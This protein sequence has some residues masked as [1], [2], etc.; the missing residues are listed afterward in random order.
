MEFNVIIMSDWHICDNSYRNVNL[1][2]LTMA[3]INASSTDKMNL[4]LFSGDI[5]QSGKSE[6]YDLALA[7]F[8]ELSE[9][10]NHF[11]IKINYM[12]SPGNHDVLFESEDK[13]EMISYFVDGFISNPSNKHIQSQ[14]LEPQSNY[15]KFIKNVLFDNNQNEGDEF[16]SARKY[17]FDNHSSLSIFSLN[18][19]FMSKKHEIYG[20]HKFPFQYYEDFVNDYKSSFNILF[21]HHPLNWFDFDTRSKQHDYIS[22]KQNLI[23]VGHEHYNEDTL[24][25]KSNNCWIK[26]EKL[27][28][29]DGN[30]AFISVN[31]SHGTIEKRVYVYD[32]NDEKYISS[33]IPSS[34]TSMKSTDSDLQLNNEFEKYLKDIGMLILHPR[35]QI[36]LEDI[37]IE[38]NLLYTKHKNET[39]IEYDN[40]VEEIDYESFKYCIIGEERS[41]KTTILKKLFIEFYKKNLIP[42][43]IK[44]EDLELV[45]KSVE[46]NIKLILE[47]NYETKLDYNKSKDRFVI[48]IDNI[49]SLKL[50]N[51]KKY[52]DFINALFSSFNKIIITNNTSTLIL[53]E[54]LAEHEFN[55]YT[56]SLLKKSQR[57]TLINKWIKFNNDISSNELL[58]QYEE[59]D[60]AISKLMRVGKFKTYPSHILL[61]M[62]LYSGNTDLEASNENFFSFCHSKLVSNTLAQYYNGQDQQN[63]IKNY[64]EKLSELYYKSEKN[65][66]KKSSYQDFHEKY[67]AD[68]AIEPNF[69][70]MYD[71]KELISLMEKASILV[72]R[73]NIIKFKHSYTYYY[74]FVE[75]IQHAKIEDQKEIINNIC[76]NLYIDDYANIFIYLVHK[77]GPKLLDFIYFINDNLEIN[78]NILLMD[79]QIIETF[80]PAI[81]MKNIQQILDNPDTKGLTAD[82]R[83]QSAI[84]DF[85]DSE[86]DYTNNSDHESKSN[87]PKEVN[88]VI[89]AIR[90]MEIGSIILKHYWGQIQLDDKNKLIYL[91]LTNGLGIG[92]FFV[93]TV[94]TVRNILTNRTVDYAIEL[95]SENV[96]NYNQDQEIKKHIEEMNRIFSNWVFV[97]T[98]ATI[99][100]I[101]DK[102][103]STQI[104][105]IVTKIITTDN[106]GYSS[107]LIELDLLIK[108]TSKGQIKNLDEVKNK[109]NDVLKEFK[110]F[111]FGKSLVKAIIADLFYNYD[112]DY[113]TRQSINELV[114]FDNKQELLISEQGKQSRR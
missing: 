50:K 1:E 40:F 104:E 87:T 103:K 38:P 72:E 88:E 58:Q 89:I 32:N 33:D 65:E 67:I 75:Y 64:L 8:R 25:L 55:V 114:K 20:H 77:I 66:I 81:E 101:S 98:Y 74:F 97:G 108:P 48:L 54:E 34:I 83:R 14:L 90:L 45:N 63:A 7:F 100:E 29:E 79:E 10:S 109:I 18:S 42:I 27:D 93:N 39:C 71:S 31:Y 107:K 110:N 4:L 26:A 112:I 44:G 57:Y 22:G 105:S 70:K 35:G 82:K 15:Q 37:F 51:Q 84:K 19:A 28:N 78:K 113:P 47:S 86:Y 6:E 49:D 46:T 99:K 106:F 68:Y 30:S 92:G 59:A 21:M 96:S 9:R 2:Q 43:F 17:S 5:V 111:S 85:D 23:I 95:K 13:E 53:S 91:I 76:D 3:I 61:F 12:F 94:S 41:G 52:E 80:A 69:K 36:Y 102:L 16:L 11:G 56:I 73:D 62:S 60:A 24:S